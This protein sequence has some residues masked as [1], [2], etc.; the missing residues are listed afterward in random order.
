M[1]RVT[2]IGGEFL[3]ARDPIALAALYRVK[4]GNAVQEWNGTQSHF[5]DDTSPRE[6]A[7]AVWSL[8][9]ADTDHFGA[10][11]QQVMVNFRVDDLAAL[12]ASLRAAG[13]DVAEKTLD[14][15]CG[16]FGWVRDPEGNRV[17]LWQPPA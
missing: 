8:F 1:A 3:R 13:C 6:H 5:A 2:G 10:A 9:P 17:E 7:Y 15:S 4:L 16:H 14:E 12:L 11:T